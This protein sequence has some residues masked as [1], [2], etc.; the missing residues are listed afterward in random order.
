MRRYPDLIFVAALLASLTL[1]AGCADDNPDPRLPP[2]SVLP[3]PGTP[4]QLVRNF[5]TFYETM[6]ADEVG[7]LFYPDFRFFLQESTIQA[8]PE[9]GTHLDFEEEQGIHLGMFSG[10][11]GRDADGQLT[12]PISSIHVDFPVQVTEWGPSLP[13]D[14]LPGVTS[15]LFDVLMEFN[16]TG[17]PIIKVQGAVKFY[18]A[19]RDSLHEGA[20]RTHYRFL[21]MGDFT[22][23]SKSPI[24]N[25]DAAY[26]AVQALFRAYTPPPLKD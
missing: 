12:N 24:D 5:K 7:T 19:A 3:F 14:P 15:A 2:A 6:D 4:D 13:A 1:T 8:F 23:D 17:A 16:R 22:E 10:Q 26:G 20:A 18:I 9:L 21:G 25:E 11:S